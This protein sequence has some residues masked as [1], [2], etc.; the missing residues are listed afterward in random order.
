MTLLTGVLE[1]IKLCLSK[2]LKTE[3]HRENLKT[4]LNDFSTEKQ[5]PFST[6]MKLL[7]SAIS[8]LKVQCSD[9]CKIN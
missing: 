1:D 5:L 8:G 9:C 2:L 4:L 7:R 6:L 3:F